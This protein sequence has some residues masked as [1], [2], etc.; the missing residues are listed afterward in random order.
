MG[1]SAAD[2]NAVLAFLD[3]HRLAHTPEHFTFAHRYLYGA[4]ES[5]RASIT[6]ITDG[7]VRISPDEVLRLNPQRIVEAAN[8]Q[9]PELDRIAMRVLDI[10]GEAASVTGELHRDLAGVPKNIDAGALI[11]TMIQRIATTEERLLETSRQTQALR[12]ELNAVRSDAERDHLTGLLTRAAMTRRMEA[13]ISNGLSCVIAFVDVD[14]FKSI[15][16]SHGHGVGD[17]VL[18]A[19]ASTL[20]AGCSPHQVARWGGEEFIVLMEGIALPEA[21]EIVDRSRLAMMERRMKLRENDQPLGVITFSA[22]LAASSG[23]TAVEVV[24]IAD[25]LLYE[26]KTGGRNRVAVEA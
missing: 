8:D 11:A 18:K 6:S 5:F 7:G 9:A 25:R 15:N 23:R 1:R 4:D 12:D 24:D 17:R 10:V 3:D 13:A 21:T 16:D 2:G 22:G 14:R 19:V 20:A 26:A